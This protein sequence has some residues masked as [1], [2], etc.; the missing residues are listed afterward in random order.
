M[1]N[2]DR[3]ENYNKKNGLFSEDTLSLRTD[4]NKV[5]IYYEKKINKIKKELDKKEFIIIDPKTSP[6]FDFNLRKDIRLRINIFSLYQSKYNY[7]DEL[8]SISIE[9]TGVSDLN[10]DFDSNNKMLIS[11]N[12]TNLLINRRIQKKYDIEMKVLLKELNLNTI[13]EVTSLFINNCYSMLNEINLSA[14]LDNT[15][16]ESTRIINDFFAINDI[17]NYKSKKDFSKFIEGKIDIPFNN[18]E[19]LK[20]LFEML[21]LQEDYILPESKKSIL[22]PK[23]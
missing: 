5:I 21:S 7:N 11:F 2:L 17:L 9:K 20:A 22:N 14:S 12:P 1:Y 23:V 3:V 4:I 15:F 10:I 6:R 18:V 16:W 8:A 19:K 13:E